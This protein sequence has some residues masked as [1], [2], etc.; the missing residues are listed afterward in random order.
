MAATDYQRTRARVVRAGNDTAHLS[1]PAWYGGQIT[2][3]TSTLSLMITTGLTRQEL[4]G[5]ELAVTA[6]L[7]ATTDADVDPHDWLLA[8]PAGQ[9][10]ATRTSALSPAAREKLSDPGPVRDRHRDRSSPARCSSPSSAPRT[11]RHRD[12]RALCSKAA[13]PSS[14]C[15]PH[16]D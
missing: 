16:H 1:L 12:L 10:P 6:N 15:A 4:L 8:A 13:S 14:R 3:P 2:V 7:A 5:A 11:Q 9:P